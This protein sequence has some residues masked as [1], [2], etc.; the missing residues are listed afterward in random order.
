[1]RSKDA[2]RGDVW[3]SMD[4]EG[5][6]RFLEWTAS[7]DVLTAHPLSSC[8][9]GDHPATSACDDSHELRGHPGIFVTDGASVPTSLCVNPSLT[10]AALAE[11]AAHQIARRASSYGVK[12]REDVPAPARS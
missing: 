5:V 7:P 10:I 2:V 6:A 3:R 9:I 11:R 1:M 12:T 4:R 8:R